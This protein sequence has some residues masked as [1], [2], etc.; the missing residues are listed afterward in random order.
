M[1]KSSAFSWCGVLNDFSNPR[2]ED[3]KASKKQYEPKKPL[4]VAEQSRMLKAQYDL[5]PHK[6]GPYRYKELK[7]RG[8]VDENGFVAMGVQNAL[9][10]IEA[11]EESTRPGKIV[12]FARCLNRENC[13]FG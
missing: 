13:C 6:D 3:C 4:P 1:S 9:A 11:E 8:L 10:L 2:P 12:E 7:A 5:I